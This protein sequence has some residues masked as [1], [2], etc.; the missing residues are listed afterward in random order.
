LEPTEARRVKQQRRT[1]IAV[2]HGPNLDMLGTREPSVYGM[3]TLRDVDAGIR[4]LCDELGCDVTIEQHNGEG[5][6]IDAVHR[7]AARASAIVINPGA[8]THYSY[9]LRDALAAAA[10]PTVEAHFSNTQAREAFRR[11]SVI[12]AVVN[13]TVGGFGVDSYL[14]AIRAACGLLEKSGAA[15]RTPQRRRGRRV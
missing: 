7:A 13:G 6:L 11:R 2:I 5:E 8:Y 10:V 9:A 14:L 4:R 3:A 12:A 1:S 15:S